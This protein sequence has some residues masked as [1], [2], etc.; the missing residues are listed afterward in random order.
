MRLAE[1]RLILQ[2]IKAAG[3]GPKPPK[4]DWKGFFCADE[5]SCVFLFSPSFFIPLLLH[6]ELHLS[7]ICS[8][9][10]SKEEGRG[11]PAL[12]LTPLCSAPL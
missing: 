8:N 5:D 7:P 11:V 3:A 2:L 6:R 9:L 12:L 4:G 1:T 10:G